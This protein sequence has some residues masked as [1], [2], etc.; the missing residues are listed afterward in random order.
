[1]KKLKTQM[2]VIL[3]NIALGVVD[4]LGK[5]RRGILPPQAVLLNYAIGYNVVNRSIY[6]AAELGIA[7]L[8]KDGPK[9]IEQLAEESGAN[10]DSL[11]RIMRTLASEGIFK[12][13]G[14]EE[15]A[16]NRL[17]KQLQSDLEDS[18]CAFIKAAGANWANDVW[19]DVLK[20]AKTGKDYYENTYGENIFEWLKNNPEAQKV[21]DVGMTSTSAISDIPV[22][23]AYDFSSFDSI[24]DLGGGYGGQILAILKANPKLK[25]VL[26][27]LPLTIETVKKEKINEKSGLN[28]RLECIAGSFFESIPEGHDAY[29]MKNILHDWDDPH[30]VEILSNCRKAMRDDSTMLVVDNIIKEDYNEQD[31]N[32]LL[33][34]SLL[35]MFGGRV[36][37]RSEWSQL[38]E[39]SGLKL[40]KIIPTPSPFILL[41]AKPF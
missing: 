20:T 3:M 18:M 35:T 11:L 32:K 23:E 24:V 5:L 41:E 36:R 33:D 25:G 7:D 1:M 27:D 6:V 19:N 2:K 34:V 39:K 14:K 40:K 8:L 37:T 10:A 12:A 31:F 4:F 22:A 9:S 26:F 13:K 28:G 30:V 17:G 21:F 15:F 38:F 16:T 29:F